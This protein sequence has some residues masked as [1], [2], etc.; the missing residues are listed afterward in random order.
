MGAPNMP[1]FDET[2]RLTATA[3][4]TGQTDLTGGTSYS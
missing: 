1:V 4:S 2:A 3:V